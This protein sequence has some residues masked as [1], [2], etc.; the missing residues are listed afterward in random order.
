MNQRQHSLVHASAP[1]RA[2]TRPA[3]TTSC[4]TGLATTASA[5]V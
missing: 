5:T 3:D 1:L 4:R 2:T